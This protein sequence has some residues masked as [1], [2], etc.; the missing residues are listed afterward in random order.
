MPPLINNVEASN[1]KVD[2]RD[3]AATPTIFQGA[4]EGQVLVKN[5]NNALPLSA[6]RSLSIFGYDAGMPPK[7]DPAL[8]LAWYLGYNSV[9]VTDDLALTDLVDF[10]NFPESATKG[11][12]ICGGGSG[13]N[14]PSYISTPLDALTNQAA[15]DGTFLTWDIESPDPTVYVGSDVC[16][17]LINE[18]ATEGIDRPGLADLASD[19]LVTNVAEQC[20]NTI[21]VIHNAGIRLVDAWIENPN[22]TAVIF[23]HL[24][25]QDSG[26]ALV[27]ILYGYQSPSGRLPY[28]VAKTT[29]DYGEL[30]YPTGMQADSPY[31]PQSISY[32]PLGSDSLLID[33][34]Q[35]TSQKEYT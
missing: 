26:K 27:E 34:G 8:S 18:F 1:E 28:T 23:A 2:G 3:P 30:L 21:V 10:P 7:D 5:S 32:F 16:L 29:E 9:N 14:A 13:A 15:K 22:V 31:Y 33:N 35:A 17:V 6:P 25:G 12:L 19:E 24:P 4:V 11:T 20:S